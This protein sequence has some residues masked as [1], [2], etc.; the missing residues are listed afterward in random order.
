MEH[1]RIKKRS[2][3]EHLLGKVNFIIQINPADAEFKEYKE[4]LVRL[5]NEV[6]RL[7]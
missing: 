6:N 5:K 1:K 3:L 2:Y 4:Y 7:M